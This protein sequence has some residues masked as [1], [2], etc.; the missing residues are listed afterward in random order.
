MANKID[1]IFGASNAPPDRRKIGKLL[2]MATASDRVGQFL[3]GIDF[4]PLMSAV[5]P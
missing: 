4:S 3:A 5:E 2:A 1:R